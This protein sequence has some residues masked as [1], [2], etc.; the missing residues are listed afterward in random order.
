MQK[1]SKIAAIIILLIFT[2]ILP[3]FVVADSP[4]RTTILTAEQTGSN[5]VFVKWKPI[6]AI[7]TYQLHKSYK[8]EKPSLVKTIYGTET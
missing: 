6:D 7:D 8:G 3:G 4:V 2:I 5:Q 1:F